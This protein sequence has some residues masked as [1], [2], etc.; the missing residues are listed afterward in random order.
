MGGIVKRIFPDDTFVK[1][2]FSG[3]IAAVINAYGTKWES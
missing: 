3:V 2:P 1:F